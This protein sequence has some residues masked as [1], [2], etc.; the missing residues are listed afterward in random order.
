MMDFVFIY[1]IF[2]LFFFYFILLFFI[3]NLDKKYDMTLCIIVT[4]I[5]KYNRDIISVIGWLYI[6]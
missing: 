4:Q 5:T 6:S 1:F 3:L 2:L